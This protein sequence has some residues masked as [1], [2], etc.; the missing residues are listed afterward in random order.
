VKTLI[1]DSL[2]VLNP[3]TIAIKISQPISYFLDTLSSE[4]AL[5]VEP[6]LIAKYGSK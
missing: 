2:V 5:V 6:A 1:G 4:S 3:N